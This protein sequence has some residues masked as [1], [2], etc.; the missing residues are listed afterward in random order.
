LL[1]TIVM[2][3]MASCRTET[4]KRK[5]KNMLEKMKRIVASAGI[6]LVSTASNDPEQFCVMSDEQMDEIIAQSEIPEKLMMDVF[7]VKSL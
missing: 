7:D 3:S 4:K 5:G 6:A 1:R 2:S